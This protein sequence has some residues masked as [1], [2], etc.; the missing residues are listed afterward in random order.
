MGKKINL[1]ELAEKYKQDKPDGN[2]IEE[3]CEGI[4]LVRKLKDDE[5][6]EVSF[7]IIGGGNF[8]SN[9]AVV[10]II[11]MLELLDHQVIQP[12]RGEH[13]AIMRKML[14]ELVSAYNEMVEK[15]D[16]HMEQHKEEEKKE[17]VKKQGGK[18]A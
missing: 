14:E 18:D 11:S 16:K 8:K 9:D 4:V 5:E 12:K 13:F 1:I 17:V 7:N 15:F 10:T 6:G 3:K 2:L